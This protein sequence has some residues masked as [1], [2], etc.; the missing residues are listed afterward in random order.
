MVLFTGL[1]RGRGW[2]SA[3]KQQHTHRRSFRRG[4]RKEY[5]FSVIYEEGLLI[6]TD[7]R[8]KLTVGVLV[9]GLN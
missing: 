9:L 2:P 5:E 8:H 3:L 7:G 1:P 4:V 6:T